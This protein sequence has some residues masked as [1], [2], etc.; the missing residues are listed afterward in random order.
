VGDQQ[1]RLARLSHQAQQLLLHELAGHGVQGCEGLVAEQHLG[2]VGE[3]A[4]HGH[5]L[6]GRTKPATMLST[7]LLP[8][9][10][11]P[12]TVSTSPRSTLR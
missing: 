3:R 11:G 1:H 5:P 2:L 9:R 10:D 7:V 8:Q 4:A 12:T 6:L